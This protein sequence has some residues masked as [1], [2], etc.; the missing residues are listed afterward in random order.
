MVAWEGALSLP[1]TLSYTELS[2]CQWLLE[3]LVI[4][5]LFIWTLILIRR[6]WVRYSV[7]YSQIHLEDSNWFLMHLNSTYVNYC[8]TRYY[9]CEW[10]CKFLSNTCLFPVWFVCSVCIFILH[11]LKTLLEISTWISKWYLNS[12]MVSEPSH[13]G[14]MIVPAHWTSEDAG[15]PQNSPM[16]I[17]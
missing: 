15:F 1:T 7:R 5:E 2:S 11:F 6:P 10:Y 13:A 4:R 12:N 14:F 8:N 9:Y 3:L 17:C 16:M